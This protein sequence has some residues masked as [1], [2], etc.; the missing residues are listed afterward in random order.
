MNKR[1]VSKHQKVDKKSNAA[2][3]DALAGVLAD[4]YALAVKTHGCHWN[5]TGAEFISLH[6]LFDAQY[7]EL[8]A[9][10]D[11]LAERIRAL[12]VLAPMGMAALQARSHIQVEGKLTS[13]A[14]MIKALLAD[15]LHLS[16]HV[17]GA[18]EA[19]DD[20]DDEVSEDILIARK[21]AHDKT[22][23]MLRSLVE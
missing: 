8:L 15:H 5:V 3:A 17:H 22:A 10:A 2:M 11:I 12:G 16:Q 23:W 18:I 21:A 6:E 14:A 20:L 4:T 13:A 9:A 7:T 1:N 19:A